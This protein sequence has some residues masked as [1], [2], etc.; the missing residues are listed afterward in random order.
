M[1]LCKIGSAEVRRPADDG[2]MRISIYFPRNC[3]NT[4]PFCTSR[5]LYSMWGVNA[6]EVMRKCEAVGK[7]KISVITITGGEPFTD[8]LK[9]EQMLDM[10]EG[11]EVYINTTLLAADVPAAVEIAAAHP[12]VKGYSV[13]RH[14][15]TY[16]EDLA[17]LHKCADDSQVVT[18]PCKLRVNCVVDPRIH[19]DKL[20]AIIKRW[21]GMFAHKG[22]VMDLSFREDYNGV[23]LE[24][25]HCLDTPVVRLLTDP[26]LGLKYVGQ[27]DCHVC[28][29]LLFETEE[30]MTV[31]YHRGLAQTR[32][33]LGCITEIESLVLFPDGLLAT[34]WDRT[35]EGLEEY[36]KAAN[37]VL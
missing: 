16:E 10:F 21:R 1:T 23:S 26:G 12:C 9:L 20:A 3:A 8:Y 17:M 34:D 25:L 33:K 4:C 15:A 27:S 22:G 31:R 37:V 2:D 29:N 35:T 30:G 13:S 6:D 7:S 18:L 36:C 14:G 11:K 5:A 19:P 24:N 28:D 32:L